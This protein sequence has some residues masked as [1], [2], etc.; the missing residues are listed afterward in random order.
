MSYFRFPLTRRWLRDPQLPSSRWT[1]ANRPGQ[2]ETGVE[3]NLP[4]GHDLLYRL[5]ATIEEEN[6]L[7]LGPVHATDIGVTGIVTEVA[8]IKI[9]IATE[10][11]IEIETGNETDGIRKRNT[12]AT[13]VVAA[14]EAGAVIVNDAWTAV[15]ETS[16]VEL[17]PI[18]LFSSTLF[19][20]CIESSLLAK[21]PFVCFNY[22]FNALNRHFNTVCF[23]FEYHAGFVRSKEK[24]IGVVCSVTQEV[25]CTRRQITTEKAVS[26]VSDQ[27]PD[28][29][30]RENN[31]KSYYPLR[32]LYSHLRLCVVESD[33][34]VRF[35]F[36]FSVYHCIWSS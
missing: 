18:S 21:F 17:E 32:M 10:T 23:P 11:A 27:K 8:G 13:V 4:R 7:D 9:E 34:C 6:A 24:K 30:V 36:H 33:H 5:L 35:F 14:V 29:L 1:E 28:V 25:D 31:K 20:A 2:K 3:M 19:D 12:A 26:T 15:D 22:Y 16:T